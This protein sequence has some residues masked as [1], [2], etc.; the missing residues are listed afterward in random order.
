MLDT[1]VVGNLEVRYCS[2]TIFGCIWEMVSL[3]VDDYTESWWLETSRN[4]YCSQT[5]KYFQPSLPYDEIFLRNLFFPALLLP[6]WAQHQA[7]GWQNDRR[8]EPKGV[9]HEAYNRKDSFTCGGL[10]FIRYAKVKVVCFHGPFHSQV[11]SRGRS[12]KSKLT[13]E[14]TFSIIG[15]V[16]ITFL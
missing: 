2:V 1:F 3:Y 15:T 10:S 13:T 16:A 4:R 14:G 9:V 8:N 12:S 6:A 11:R 5:C 7:L